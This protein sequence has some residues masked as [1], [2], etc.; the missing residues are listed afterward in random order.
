MSEMDKLLM[1]L[2]NMKQEKPTIR[3]KEIWD[4]IAQKKDWSDLGFKSKAEF[5]QFIS[6]NPYGNLA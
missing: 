1:E 4:G 3:S 5:E 6:D 2:I